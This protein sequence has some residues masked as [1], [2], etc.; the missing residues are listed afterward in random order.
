MQVQKEYKKA[1]QH[2]TWMPDCIRVNYGGANRRASYTPNQSTS[3][4]NVSGLVSGPATKNLPNNVL[5][6]S[7]SFRT[8][9]FKFGLAL[10]RQANQL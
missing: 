6:I 1:V 7:T 8:C 5:H 10:E 9:V 2:S 4:G 3:S